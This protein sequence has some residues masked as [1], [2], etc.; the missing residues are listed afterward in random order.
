MD[1]PYFYINADSISPPLDVVLLSSEGQIVNLTN[2]SVAARLFD[3][4]GTLID[5]RVATVL[6]EPGGKVRYQWETDDIGAVGSKTLVKFR[7]TYASQEEQD[8]PSN[9]YIEAIAI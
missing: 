3:L 2:A 1:N 8:F 5:E 7:V 9:R 4:G 6:D